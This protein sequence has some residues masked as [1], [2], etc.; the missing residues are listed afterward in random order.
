MD[1]D[2]ARSHKVARRSGGGLY[3]RSCMEVV[4]H[5]G[6]RLLWGCPANSLVLR[7]E[8]NFVIEAL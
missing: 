7:V 6:V 2:D 1:S 8:L 4:I 5:V 3:A